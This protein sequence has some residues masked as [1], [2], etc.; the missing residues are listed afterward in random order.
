MPGFWTGLLLLWAVLAFVGVCGGGGAEADVAVAVSS[1]VVLGGVGGTS[2]AAADRRRWGRRGGAGAGASGCYASTVGGGSSTRLLGVI[3]A[4][5]MLLALMATAPRER[6]MNN[7]AGGWGRGKGGADAAWAATA[8][9]G[10]TPIAGFAFHTGSTSGRPPLVVGAAAV[11]LLRPTEVER[12]TRVRLFDTS[13]SD[14][15]AAVALGADGSVYLAGKTTPATATSG[16][17]ERAL[18]AASPS[19]TAGY[20]GDDAFVAKVSPAGQLLWVKSIGSA[21]D[22]AATGVAVSAAGVFVVGHTRG[23]LSSSAKRVGAVDFFLSR[24]S[25]S[26]G[27][28][29][30]TVQDGSIGRD[31]LSAVVIGDSGDIFAAGH[32]GGAFLRPP[33]AARDVLVVRYRSDGRRMWA[34]QHQVGRA[35]SAS[36]LAVSPTDG[37]LAVGVTV[38]RSVQGDQETSDAAVVRVS[39][40]GKV[41]WTA[42]SPTFS[43]T[44][45]SAVAVDT[46]G[47]VYVGASEWKH[48]YENFNVHLRKLSSSG[49]ELWVTE[50]SSAGAHA[51]YAAAVGL[52]PDGRSLVVAGY[53][54]GNF[55]VTTKEEEAATAAVAALHSSPSESPSHFR[56]IVMQMDAITG[57][58]MVRFQDTPADVHAWQQLRALVVDLSGVLLL[59]GYER[60]LGSVDPAT[61]DA[62]ATSKSTV[63][64]LLASF[65]FRT[66]AATALPPGSAPNALAAAALSAATS[67]GT[68]SGSGNGSVSGSTGSSGGA[69]SNDSNSSGGGSGGVVGGSAAVDKS[70]ATGGDSGGNGSGD[71]HD[72]DKRGGLPLPLLAGGAAAGVALVAALAVTVALSVRASTARSV[73]RQAGPAS[74][75]ASGGAGRRAAPAAALASGGGTAA[76]AA[77]PPAARPAQPP[78]TL[79]TRTV[80][81]GAS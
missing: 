46:S 69:S 74:A 7:D 49:A 50:L 2:V 44:F 43:Q 1:T 20:G 13:S 21:A 11:N 80:F 33:V 75:A 28:V 78:G 35:S 66:S 36:A 77:R 31:A 12:M 55:L 37:S 59:A 17:I 6:W 45:V 67:G 8:R 57:A 73:D 16:T 27:N 68:T 18:P 70:P 3:V 51:D 22:E 58:E 19:T 52:S 23:Q 14:E 47:A 79:P 38:Y 5:S 81:C 15:A 60:S 40:A 54:A 56:A 65:A 41:L 42:H 9:W 53:S 25:I 24:L 26:T 10:G 29:V 61:T 63:N 76:G 72:K 48:V 32:V 71:S 39:A 62:A 34:V 4:V 30:W 64:V